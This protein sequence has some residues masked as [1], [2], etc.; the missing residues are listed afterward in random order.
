MILDL[1]NEKNKSKTKTKTKTKAKVSVYAH[2]LFEEANKLMSQALRDG[3]ARIVELEKQLQEA[4]VW[5]LRNNIKSHTLAFNRIGLSVEIDP[6]KPYEFKVSYGIGAPKMV[7][8][9]K[10]PARM[11]M[12][13][14]MKMFF[15]LIDA[16]PRLGTPLNKGVEEEFQAPESVELSKIVNKK[17]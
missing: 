17:D 16:F 11:G 3:A 5:D 15:P 13:L 8:H 2:G 10:E 9:F 7:V 6:D 4:K 12:T 14:I 1:K